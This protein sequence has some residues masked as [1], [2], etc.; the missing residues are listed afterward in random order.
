MQIQ[1]TFVRTLSK[2]FSRPRGNQRS[3][4]VP[5]TENVNNGDVTKRI[6]PRSTITNANIC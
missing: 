5:I 4:T 3:D 2:D 1:N 6:I